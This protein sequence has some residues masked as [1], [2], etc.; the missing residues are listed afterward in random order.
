MAFHTELLFECNLIFLSLQSH[1]S[2]WVARVEILM[3]VSLSL[4]ADTPLQPPAVGGKMSL[5]NTFFMK[6]DACS[7]LS[8]SVTKYALSI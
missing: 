7:L 6:T 8:F 5:P 2:M 3:V 4:Q 1:F